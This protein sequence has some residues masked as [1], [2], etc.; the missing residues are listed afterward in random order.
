MSL[1]ARLAKLEAARSPGAMP[2]LDLSRIS[3]TTLAAMADAY[4][5]TLDCPDQYRAALIERI[6]TAQA[7]GTFPASLS[8]ADL[9]AIV[10]AADDAEGAQP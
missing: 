2:A 4:G 8:D 5:E 6:G 7:D 3:E 10:Y 1:R 9:L